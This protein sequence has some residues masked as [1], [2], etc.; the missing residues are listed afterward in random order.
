MPIERA[1]P[2]ADGEDVALTVTV[3]VALAA[4]LLASG[5]LVG[6]PLDRGVTVEPTGVATGAAGDDAGTRV[7][8]AVAAR[9]GGIGVEVD[10][11]VAVLVEVAVVVD[12]IG[13]DVAA[14]AGVIVCDIEVAVRVEAMFAGTGADSRDSAATGEFAL[15]AKIGVAAVAGDDVFALNVPGVLTIGEAA[16]TGLLAAGSVGADVGDPG[17]AAVDSSGDV[18]FV[19]A[20]DAMNTAAGDEAREPPARG[21]A[22]VARTEAVV[23]T[24]FEPSDIAMGDCADADAFG[25]AMTVSDGAAGRLPVPPPAARPIRKPSA[26]LPR[27]ASAMTA[28]R[29]AARLEPINPPGPAQNASKFSSAMSLRC[30]QSRSDS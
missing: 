9:V 29:V 13:T 11:V 17:N 7:E 4:G 19:A 30:G 27:M 6:V 8:I 1:P 10:V 22:G 16:A 25:A 5:T 3:A 12:G 24:S 2:A 15:E 21:T 26:M 23:A 28:R 20:G 14:S 18:A